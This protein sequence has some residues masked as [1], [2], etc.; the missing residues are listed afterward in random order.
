MLHIIIQEIHKVITHAY[1]CTIRPLYTYMYLLALYVM[2]IHVE[3][4]PFRIRVRQQRAEQTT[5]GKRSTVSSRCVNHA[6]LCSLNGYCATIRSSRGSAR[7][8]SPVCIHIYAIPPRHSYRTVSVRFCSTT[9]ACMPRGTL[10]AS[11]RIACWKYRH[12]YVS[13]LVHM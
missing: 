6:L 9:R 8:M 3:I 13:T 12:A 1:A 11:V 10:N 5:Q 4:F 7:L 2:R